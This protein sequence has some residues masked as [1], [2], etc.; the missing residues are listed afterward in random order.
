[1]RSVAA[2]L[3]AALLVAFISLRRQILHVKGPT[4]RHIASKPPSYCTEILGA[5][6]GDVGAVKNNGG[7]QSWPPGRWE[8]NITGFW[9][10]ATGRAEARVVVCRLWQKPLSR[11][12]QPM[13]ALSSS[14]PTLLW[15]PAFATPLE[16]STLSTDLQVLHRVQCRVHTLLRVPQVFAEPVQFIDAEPRLQYD[17]CALL[18]VRPYPVATSFISTETC[19]VLQLQRPVCNHSNALVGRPVVNGVVGRRVATVW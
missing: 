4:P 19:R 10:L 18:Q 6:H 1:M 15:V 14:A 12:T 11:D 8:L 3:C 17:A 2:V 7:A 9:E 13:Q 5:R 16:L